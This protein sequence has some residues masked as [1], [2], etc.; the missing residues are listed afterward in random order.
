[1]HFTA[2]DDGLALAWFGA[3]F[4]NP[5]YGRALR[6]WTTKAR[7]EW[8]TGCARLIIGLVP[9]RTDTGWWHDDIAPTADVFFLRGRLSFGDA[10]QS[11]PFP[12]ALAIWGG[13]A[14]QLE[15]LV[16]RWPGQL[17]RCLV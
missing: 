4:F 16:A 10:Q 3:V 5:P 9:A 15:N 6:H 7:Q 14:S 2:A 12:S 8:Q 17:Q 13:D 11:A 1:M